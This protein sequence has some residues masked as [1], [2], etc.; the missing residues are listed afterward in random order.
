[1]TNEQ[2]HKK[3][4]YFHLQQDQHGLV[5]IRPNRSEM[6]GEN[7]ITPLAAFVN[8]L[9]DLLQSSEVTGVVYESIIPDTDLDYAT[10][11]AYLKTGNAAKQEV[12]TLLAKLVALKDAGKPIVAILHGDNV[13]LRL[14]TALWSDYRIAVADA[15]LG[16]TE[17]KQGLFPGFGATTNCI[18]LLG[19]PKTLPFLFS[20]STVSAKQA[21]TLGLVNQVVPNLKEAISVAK[22]W[23]TDAP[24]VENVQE[25]LTAEQVQQIV[26]T[27][28]EKSNLLIPAHRALLNYVTAQDQSSLLT[29]LRQENE[30]WFGLL[31][32]PE[33][34]PMVRT[35]SQHVQ[36][37][38]KAGSDA[39]TDN[40]HLKK[41]GVLGAGMMGSGIAYEA[42]RAGLAVVLK[43][44][45]QATAERG[46]AYAEKVTDRQV[47]R[48]ERDASSQQALLARIQATHDVQDLQD[49]DI[50]IEAVFENQELKAAVTLESLPYLRANGVFA[51]NT[52]SLPITQLASV[53]AAPQQFIGMHFFSPV[54]RMPLVEIIRG[55]QTSE[56]TLQKA[57]VLAHRLQ[58]IP[59]VVFD[60][61]A[62]FTS[63]IFFNYL[64]EAISM[65]L[66]GIPAQLIE[67]EAR[68]AGFA[69][70]PLAVLDEI[71]L[72]LMLQVYDQL[73]A[74]HASQQR[75]YAYL[76]SLVEQGRQG[77]KS[78]QGFY[79]YQ[80]ETGKKNIWNDPSIAAIGTLP[81]RASLQKRLLHV[82][83]LDSY[84]CLAE[85]VV[86]KPADADIGSVLG[87]GY[88]IHTGGVFSHI[89]QVGIR[90][91]V[92]DCQNFS[93]FGEQWHMPESLVQLAS[94]NF[95]FYHDFQSN[96]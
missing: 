32:A 5:H 96:W 31:E 45:D 66:E 20:A 91:F 35:F 39:L 28:R 18:H 10:F 80:Q 30:A 65:L 23:I 7:Y 1:M 59:I 64:L 76:R 74:L 25:R 6:S 89:D 92:E 46:K 49:A 34:L 26:H 12:D 9:S 44:V 27:A 47:Q 90:A 73:P 83:A 38:K 61:P 15:I 54:D 53:V 17:L 57:L 56:E 29:A 68:Q 95:N 11:Y 67:E 52:T 16:F 63:R 87:V 81:A 79:D 42:A 58:K 71:S 14:A 36:Q 43:D 86:T 78:G 93:P 8:T 84:R 85:G 3:S 37:A 19:L 88:P 70:G 48:Q 40:F 51:S 75:C 22:K 82:M 50:I 41:I 24:R 72:T 60:S 69:I 33:T 13:G 94:K 55:E 4:T 77:R 2:Q 62:F 21:Q